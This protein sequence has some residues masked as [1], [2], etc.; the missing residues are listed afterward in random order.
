AG[1]PDAADDLV[2]QL[3]YN[4]TGKEQDVRQLGEERERAVALGAVEQNRRVV[5]EGDAGIGLVVRAIEGVDAGAVAAHR[6]DRGAVGV[7]ND[8]GLGV[9]AFGA[10]RDRLTR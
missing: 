7:D 6:R 5:L 10:G 9:A 4:A 2:V 3:D 8:N 1:G